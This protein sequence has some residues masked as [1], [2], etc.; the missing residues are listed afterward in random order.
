ML[1]LSIVMKRWNFS[2]H[3]NGHKVLQRYFG[4]EILACPWS[5]FRVKGRNIV[6]VESCLQNS[7]LLWKV[8]SLQRAGGVSECFAVQSW[9]SASWSKP[10]GVGG[11]R[12]GPLEQ[13]RYRF[14]GLL[15]LKRKVGAFSWCVVVLLLQEMFPLSHH[16]TAWAESV[17]TGPEL[18]C[19]G[20]ADCGSQQVNAWTWNTG[21]NLWLP[22]KIFPKLLG[23]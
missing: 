6:A 21:L 2:H 10:A 19:R 15:V 9:G 1:L 22:V 17:L 23:C 11:R 18:L 16:V 8:W 12:F 14:I 7:L 3:Q 13:R 4:S 5:K 20:K